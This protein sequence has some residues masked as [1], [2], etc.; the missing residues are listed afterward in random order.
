MKLLAGF[1]MKGPFQAIAVAGMLGALSQYVLPLGLIS[2]GVI[3]LCVLTRKDLEWLIVLSVT[4]LIIL[5][6]QQFVV[7]RPGL[8]YPLILFLLGPVVVCA[9]TLKVTESQSAAIFLAVIFAAITALAVHFASGNAVQWWSDWLKIAVEGVK[10]AD[11]DGFLKSGT[12]L[13][14]NGLIGM[15]FAF[16]ISASVFIGRWLQAGLYNPGGFGKEFN[17]IKFT[18]THVI[19]MGVVVLLAMLVK[20]RLAND[21]ILIFA[22]AF[23]FQGMSVLHYTVAAQDKN[24]YYLWP[25]YLLFF[26]MPHYVVFGMATVGIV[27]VLLNF[28]KS[29]RVIKR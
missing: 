25:P 22:V 8:G 4:V 20:E 2:S 15:L 21:L 11:Y 28:R 7:P 13:L 19:S 10:E 5:I 26:V 23:F 9:K 1:V 24:K 16:A 29:I 3:A 6:S 27:D 17:Q 18:W 14:M 12:L